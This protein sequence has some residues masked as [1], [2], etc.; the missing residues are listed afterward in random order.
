[1]KKK[2][3]S[4]FLTF[5]FREFGIPYYV[6]LGL[7]PRISVL[8]NFKFI[9]DEILGSSRGMTQKRRR[10]MTEFRNDGILEFLISTLLA[11]QIK[12][13]KAKLYYTPSLQQYY[14]KS[15]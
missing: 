11:A 2:A 6:I 15:Q 10:T 14:Q 3:K 12:L 4:I 5:Q 13:L 1:M 8:G 7:D 9:C